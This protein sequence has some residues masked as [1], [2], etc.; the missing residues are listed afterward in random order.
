MLEN[1]RDER[2]PGGLQAELIGYLEKV[3][4]TEVRLKTWPEVGGLPM[5]LARGYDFSE[6]SIGQARLL[7]MAVDDASEATPSDVAKHVALVRDAYRGPVVYAARSMTSTYRDRLI[8]AAVSFVVPGNQLYLPE[9]AIDL[10]E[11][12]RSPKPPRPDRLT[13]AAQAVFFRY[14]LNPEDWPLTATELAKPLGYSAMTIGR[15]FD[16]L[17]SVGLGTIS[18]PGRVKLLRFSPGSLT[19][20]EHAKTMLSSPVQRTHR[21]CW[22]S[23]PERF[24]LAGLSALGTRTMI[25][26]G[27]LATFALSQH[28]AKRVMGHPVAE[29]V[30]D[31]AIADA[32][33]EV[34]RYDPRSLGDD[35]IVDPLSLYAQFWDHPDERIAIAADELLQDVLW[36]ED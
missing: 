27:D 26:G 28:E 16:D 1:D 8:D 17:A 35:R 15:A 13:P 14:L 2:E 22:R 6:A 21:V 23:D 30:G 4:H 20:I 3:L 25:D 7:V 36:S 10:R 5:F 24:P 29:E 32:L 11:H 18:R 12:F 19:L 31:D 34:W 33:L 9:L